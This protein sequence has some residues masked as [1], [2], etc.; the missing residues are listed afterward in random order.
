[1]N[2]CEKGISGWRAA[3]VIRGTLKIS[4]WVAET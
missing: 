3:D 2:G 1:M 4:Q